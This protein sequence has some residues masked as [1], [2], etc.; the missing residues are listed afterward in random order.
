[1]LKSL[2]IKYLNA[3]SVECLVQ[4]EL[5]CVECASNSTLEANC[6]DAYFLFKLE[7]LL[8]L[9]HFFLSR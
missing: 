7:S 6:W 8:V 1:M 9:V 2:L 5:Q 4:H 3:V